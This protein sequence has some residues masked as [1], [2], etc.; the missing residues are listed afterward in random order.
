MRHIPRIGAVLAVGVLAVTVYAQEQATDFQGPAAEEF[1]LHAK[2][3]D[4]HAIG[5]GV[6][7]P[8]KAVLE[9]NGVRHAAAFKTIDEMKSGFTALGQGG[10]VNFQ[11]TWHTEIAAY[12]VDKIIGLGMVPA[13]VER[14]LRSEHGSL[15]WWVESLMSEAERVKKNIEVPDSEDWN[16]QMY[17]VR[18]FDNLIYNV[19]RNLYNLLITKDYQIRLIDHSRAF[20][21][22][23]TPRTPKDLTR[24]S[25]SLLERLQKL[26]KAD[27]T[28]RVGKHLTGYQI[29]ALLQRRDAIVALA[30]ALVAQRGEAAVLYP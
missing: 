29:S 8:E 18:L 11:D 16:R 21:V 28:A 5:R 4:M 20:R 3:I 23:N 19:D 14:V 15:Q 24:F 9:M 2:L 1:L 7:L 26:E 30:A 13:T 12:Q 22:I 25:K 10:E 6:T 27:L 17:K